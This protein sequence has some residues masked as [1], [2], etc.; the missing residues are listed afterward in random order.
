MVE[1]KTQIKSQNSLG[2]NFYRPKVYAPSVS[3]AA[4]GPQIPTKNRSFYRDSG[5]ST[6]C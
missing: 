6:N 4:R 5:V 2:I 1:I 3:P